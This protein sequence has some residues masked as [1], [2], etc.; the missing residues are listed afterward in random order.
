[1]QCGRI[2]RAWLG[3]DQQPNASL[4]ALQTQCDRIV[5]AWLGLLL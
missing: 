2:L 5:R 4:S 1:M 3:N